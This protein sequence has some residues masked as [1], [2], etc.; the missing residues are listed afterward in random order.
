MRKLLTIINAMLKYR[1]PWDPIVAHDLGPPPLTTKT[2]AFWCPS[3]YAWGGHRVEPCHFE[4]IF[5]LARSGSLGCVIL[6]Q[7]TR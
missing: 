6:A 4:G 7:N 3:F 1:T 2:V 5:R